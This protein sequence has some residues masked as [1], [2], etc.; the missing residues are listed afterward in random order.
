MPEVQIKQALQQFDSAVKSGD[1]GGI[2]SSL[3][4]LE[5]LL[6][7]HRAEIHPQLVHFL[8]G[9][10]YAKALAYLGGQSEFV[11]PSSPPGGCGNH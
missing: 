11:K 2:S 5:V 4:Q 7:A 9:R 1:G 3:A 6:G 8:E 10:S